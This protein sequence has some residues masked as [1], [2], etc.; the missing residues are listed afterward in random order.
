[1]Q[2]EVERMLVL[3]GSPELI[4]GRIRTHRSELPTISPEAI[5]QWIYDQRPD[6]I[7]HLLRAHPKRRK[8]C[9]TKKRGIRIP[10]RK[11]ILE[12]PASIQ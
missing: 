5:Y 2:F 9:K 7:G 4:S 3:G 10:E 11:S 6:L 8:R 1:M 12:R